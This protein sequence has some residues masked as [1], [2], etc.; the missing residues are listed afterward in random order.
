MRH[1]LKLL[2]WLI[3]LVCIPISS[4]IYANESYELKSPK[5]HAVEKTVKAF[6]NSHDGTK[7][8]FIITLPSKKHGEEKF[9]L[10]VLS[11]PLGLPAQIY[12]HT[13][14]VDL[15]V[16][17]GVAVAML[18]S[19][20]HFLS[21]GVARIASKNE[22][23]DI[24]AF[25]DYSIENYSID[26]D[27]IALGGTSNGAG[28]SLRNAAIDNR[29]KA[30]VAGSPWASLMEDAFYENK[31]VNRMWAEI[32]PV[33]FKERPGEF[34]RLLTDTLLTD[35]E[36]EL[37]RKV[38]EDRNIYPSIEKI[39]EKNIPTF[40]ISSLD[41]SLFPVKNTIELFNKLNVPKKLEL[42][43]GDHTGM[44]L[45]TPVVR[46][47]GLKTQC[48][49]T[50]EIWH[51]IAAW[52]LYWL[53]GA[54][55][56]IVKEDT[57]FSSVKSKKCETDSFN[58]FSFNAIENKMYF[59]DK[60]SLVSKQEDIIDANARISVTNR[61]EVITDLKVNPVS[62]AVG[63]S[64]GISSKVNLR[65][66]ER[67]F[68]FVYKTEPLSKK[69]RLRTDFYINIRV[70]SDHE[71]FQMFFYIL[72][73]SKKDKKAHLLSIS[74]FSN[75]QKTSDGSYL[76]KYKMDFI[77]DDLEVGDVIYLA[78]DTANAQYL[79][80]N[81]A[82][83]ISILSSAEEPSYIS[84]KA[85]D[86]L[87]Y[88]VETKSETEVCSSNNG[89]GYGKLYSCGD[90]VCAKQ[91]SNYTGKCKLDHSRSFMSDMGIAYCRFNLGKGFRKAECPF[92]QKG[93]SCAYSKRFSSQKCIVVD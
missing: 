47:V 1:T 41:E 12:Q 7:L 88:G 82:Q 21:G 2:F 84:F 74:P 51:K 68:A 85:E 76:I 13:P 11:N 80:N 63:E 40:I 6:F 45:I 57:I 73:K 91:K 79:L 89:L 48:R 77:S 16:N 56:S 8:N 42:G 49:N 34:V 27:S 36:S 5:T 24:S 72:K 29:I 81:K 62:Y 26:K 37:L 66:V 20:G 75:F 32:L 3:F 64:I 78:A 46:S 53:K 9:P 10:V 43:R 65:N 33:S 61:G 44:E 38:S 39:N 31:T 59:S 92:S 25:I 93:F 14:V 83:N 30:V 17:R 58:D 50:N 71:V 60:S 23:Q 19:R 70:K 69:I 18:N 55:D 52:Y 90:D 87:L 28:M 35:P 4:K 15:L 67:E 54:E 22:V 86:E